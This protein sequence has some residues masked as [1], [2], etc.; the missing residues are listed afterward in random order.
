IAWVEQMIDKS[1]ACLEPLRQFILPSGTRG[2]AALHVARGVC[3][4]AERR[5]VSLRRSSAEPIGEEIVQYLNRLGDLLFVLA[6]H[7]NALA[8]EP[9]HPWAK[10]QPPK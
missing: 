8:G 1:E 7:V 5:V 2:A 6:R 4:R 10:P 9:D 3:R